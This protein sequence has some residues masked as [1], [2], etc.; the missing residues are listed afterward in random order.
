MRYDTLLD[1]ADSDNIYIVENAE[2][3]SRA[4]GLING[5]V[6]GLNRNINSNRKKNVF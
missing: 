2:F 1:E 5:N 4:D 6:I 3:K